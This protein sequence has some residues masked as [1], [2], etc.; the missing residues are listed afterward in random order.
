MTAADLAGLVARYARRFHA[1]VGSGHHVASP[2]GAWLLLALCAPAA[3]GAERS[4]LVDV[5]GCEPEEAAALAAGLMEAPHP[6]VAAAAAVWNLAGMGDEQWLAGLPASV[7]RGPIPSQDQA[8]RW[9]REHTLGLIEKFPIE[10]TNEI[11]LLLATALATKVSWDRPFELAPGSA[12]GSA[13]QWGRQLEHVLASPLGHPALVASTAQAGDVAVH[14]GQARDGLLVVSVIAAPDV[15]AG[16]V[17]AAGYG[18]ATDLALGRSVPKRSLF[19]LP[20]GDGPLWSVHQEVSSAGA[21]ESCMAFLPAWEAHSLH[22]LADRRLGFAAAA[23]AL[24]KGDPWQANQAAMARYTRVGFEAAALTA[25][26]AGFGMPTPGLRRTAEL[27]FC[28]PYAV[29]AVAADDSGR[30]GETESAWARRWNGVPVF[31]AWVAE[32]HEAGNADGEAEQLRR[33]RVTTTPTPPSSP[34]SPRRGNKAA[35]RMTD[36]CGSC[37]TCWAMSPAVGCWTRG[38]ATGTS[39][40]CSPRA[41]PGSRPSTWGRG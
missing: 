19:D 18:L 21:G 34:A 3:S 24:G 8:D 36:F 12:L 7:E 1:V 14:V 10:I 9:A 15:P 38:A 6:L 26:A 32:P 13:T 31:S 2:L 5:L 33:R 41:A 17:L 11:Y 20:L 30:R 27:R 4:E 22:D 37:L 23:A 28:H 25:L 29:I 16:E 40:A 39:P 35:W